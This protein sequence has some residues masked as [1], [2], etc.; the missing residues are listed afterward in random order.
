MGCQEKSLSS[1]APIRVLVVAN[2]GGDQRYYGRCFGL[3]MEQGTNARG[4][5]AQS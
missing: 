3:A 4:I 1:F 5:V 2:V